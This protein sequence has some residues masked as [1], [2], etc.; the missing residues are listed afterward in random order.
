RTVVDNR[1]ETMG[2]KIR[3][4]EMNKLPYM[5]IVGEQ[6]EKEGSISVRKH[7]GEDLGSMSVAAFS[8][9]VQKEISETIKTFEV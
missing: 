8:E 4:A 3:E 2:K 1:A 5:L 9:L 6:E 7:G